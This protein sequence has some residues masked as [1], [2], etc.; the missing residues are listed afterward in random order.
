MS[1]TPTE[2]DPVDRDAAGIDARS[3]DAPEQIEELIEHAEELGREPEAEIEP[4][5]EEGAAT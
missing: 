1:T 5:A 3:P 2:P 4:D